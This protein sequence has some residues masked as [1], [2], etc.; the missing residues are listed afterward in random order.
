[1]NLKEKYTLV[2]SKE[3]FENLLDTLACYDIA[4]V[5][6]EADSMYHYHVKLCLIQIT[7]GHTHWIVDPLSDLN[8]T[9]LFQAKAMQTLIFHGADYDLRM[10]W[11]TYR[12]A[13]KK[14]F[15]TMLA[16]KFL[17]EEKLGLASLVEKYFGVS[18]EKENQK[19]DWTI[20]PL[21]Q[22]MCEYAVHDTFFLHE[23]CALLG[24]KLQAEG[25]FHWLIETCQNL[26]ESAK[27][28][29]LPKED[30]WRISG[31]S[32]FSPKE[33]QILKTIWI[34][35]EKEASS[36]DKPP[37][38]ILSPGFM[39]SIVRAV[40]RGT[41]GF[42]AE[43]FPRM[44]KK[45]NNTQLDSLQALIQSALAEPSD[46]WPSPYKFPKPSTLNPDGALMETLRSWRNQKALNLNLEAS[47]IANKNQLSIL[48]AL[49]KESWEERF[50]KSGLMN[51]QKKIW[52]EFLIQNQTQGFT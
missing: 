19:A 12:F 22:A 30:P 37:Y 36:A 50:Q 17:N 48:A 33:L 41:K 35:R 21:P 39:L 45:F 4:A 16:A 51:W 7:V 31:A 40:A 10:L 34:W 32:L 52:N 24:E 18:L 44:Q 27:S 2:S 42:H 11:S 26:I 6:T 29:P 23:L 25:K 15:D 5:D 47:M 9:L 49:N 38:K 14:V 8:L 3:T 1:M 43:N 13:P 20:R 28:T 46:T